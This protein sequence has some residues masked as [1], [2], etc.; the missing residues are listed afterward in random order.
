MHNYRFWILTLFIQTI[1]LSTHLMAEEQKE[2]Q[3]TDL[4]EY[5][6]TSPAVA[7]YLKTDKI[8]VR[9]FS[10]T[11]RPQEPLP[12]IKLREPDEARFRD[13]FQQILK[14]F[15]DA[16]VMTEEKG[17][18]IIAKHRE[19]ACWMHRASGGFKY[20]QKQNNVSKTSF[21]DFKEAVGTALDLVE[22][23]GI[24]Q[25]AE[26][27]ELDILGVSAINNALATVKNPQTPKELF[28]SDYY[29]SFGRRYKGVPVVGSYLVFRLD[30]GKKPVMVKMNWREIAGTGVMATPVTKEIARMVTEQPSFRKSFGEQKKPEDIV[31]TQVQSGY[32]EAPVNYKQMELRPG[33]LVSFKM[34]SEGDEETIQLVLPLE[35]EYAERSI[36]GEAVK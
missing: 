16:K 36:L 23:T 5:K 12:V 22:K 19:Y 35:A 30:A 10:Y 26:G 32:I 8:K 25:L 4:A 33:S 6:I 31:I 15:S 14:T 24:V 17:N 18:I 3:D 21:K 11:E 13:R 1:F 20:T 29:V 27:E 28:V 9:R 2:D 34:R 7:K